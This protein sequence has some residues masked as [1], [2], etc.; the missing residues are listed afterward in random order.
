MDLQSQ[1]YAKNEIKN[2]IQGLKEEC[3]AK[4]IIFERESNKLFEHYKD[5]DDEGIGYL[6]R[7]CDI[8][9]N[10]IQ[11]IENISD[12][13][14]KETSYADVIILHEYQIYWNYT[15]CLFKDGLEYKNILTDCRNLEED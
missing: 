5:Y 11:D 13:S 8:L 10:I 1:E 3:N 6:H 14:E 2:R 9:N 15:Y 12:L 7:A 4:V